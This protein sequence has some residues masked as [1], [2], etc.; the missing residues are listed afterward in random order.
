MKT[1]LFIIPLTPQFFLNFNRAEIQRKSF[2]LLLAQS[3][4]NWQAI[5]IGDELPLIL[6]DNKKF[7]HV[8]YEGIK[9]E[10]LQVATKYILE[11]KVKADYIIRLD[12]DDFFNPFILKE[13]A[14]K[15]FDIYT[16]KF[17]TFFEFGNQVFSRQIR[18]W[19]PNTCIHKFE[20]AMAV[21]GTLA[22]PNIKKINTQ[23]RLIENDHSKLHPYYKGKKIMYSNRNNP[24]YVRV[25]NRESITAKNSLNYDIY[26]KQF[27]YWQTKK[28]KNFTDI[29]DVN[30]KNKLK[31]TYP[32]KER[33]YRFFQ[34]LHVNLLYKNL[35]FK[36]I[37]NTTKITL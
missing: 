35:L 1:Y 14:N 26:L 32:L 10:K 25:L 23:V 7:I 3:Y 4:S 33:I 5:I 12:D 15:D 34:Q 37:N 29:Y 2:E 27:G 28:L 9:E 11:N 17:H 18:L 22:N 30:R 13:I 8:K 36:T 20:H 6:I 21:F 19:F 31:L 24:V 16:D